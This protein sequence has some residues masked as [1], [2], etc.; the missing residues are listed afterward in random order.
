MI[1]AVGSSAMRTT[2]ETRERRQRARL[3]EENTR[4]EA[5]LPVTEDGIASRK[6]GAANADL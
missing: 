2:P 3:G 1:S 5:N 4:M 6:A